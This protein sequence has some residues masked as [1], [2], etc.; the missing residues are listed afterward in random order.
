[1]KICLHATTLYCTDQIHIMV[2]QMNEYNYLFLPPIEYNKI[3]K[4]SALMSLFI[5]KS[6]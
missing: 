1:M 3:F 5:D 6:D 2:I 4:I